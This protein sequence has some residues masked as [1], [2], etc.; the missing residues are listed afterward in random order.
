MVTT[1]LFDFYGVFVEDTY[2]SWLISHGLKRTGAYQEVADRLDRGIITPNDFYNELSALSGQPAA[3][4]QAVFKTPKEVNASTV[5]IL[6]S[7]SSRYTIALTSN[8]TQ[9]SR[10]IL[11]HHDAEGYF[12]A[13]FNSAEM[14]LS[15][16][17]RAFFVEVLRRLD[18]AASQALLIDDSAVN[19]QAASEYGL[20]TIHFQNV[21]QL[22]TSLRSL[23]I[24]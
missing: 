4:I 15:K 13:F 14:G 24:L 2:N 16:P 11:R 21:T 22:S 20:K 5:A 12:D 10:D 3:L 17:S 23:G 19:T 9:R 7:L 18:V 1:I 6:A 8:G